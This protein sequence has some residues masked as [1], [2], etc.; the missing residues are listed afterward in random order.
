MGNAE[1]MGSLLPAL[2]GFSTLLK[3]QLLG[4]AKMLAF[5]SLASL[6]AHSHAAVLP[7]GVSAAACPNYPYCGPSPANAVPGAAS[8]LAAQEAVKAQLRL[9]AAPAPPQAPGLAAHAAAENAQLARMGMAGQP[10][11]LQAHRAAEA[12]VM[13]QQQELA[14]INNNYLG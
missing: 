8:V 7:A 3:N 10:A 14:A 13:Q 4:P 9:A 2:V 12:R 1:Y 5:L 6:I 11:G